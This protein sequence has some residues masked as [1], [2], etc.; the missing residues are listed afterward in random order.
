MGQKINPLGFRL[1]KTQVYHSFWFCK[2]KYFSMSLQEDAKIRNSI[3][4]YVKKSKKISLDLEGIV[5]IGIKK[6]IGL[7]KVIIYIGFPNLLIEGQ[8]QGLNRLQMH[9]KRELIYVNNQL[10]IL[11][12]RIDKPYEQ[13]IILAEYIALQ[14]KNRVSFQKSM[15]KAIELTE[16]TGIKGIQVKLAGR[17]DG[18]EIARVEWIREGKVPL[19]TIDAKID[20]CSHTIRTNH[21]LLGIKIW[22][23]K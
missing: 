15:K 21:G 3:K 17:I 7:I 4:D 10:N 20:Y 8:T 23:Y 19:Q 11:I 2:P 6:R 1:G 14:L 18:K 5:N 13:P 16:K 9:L 22:I 12:K